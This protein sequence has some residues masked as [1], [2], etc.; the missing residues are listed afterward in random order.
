M[1]FNTSIAIAIKNKYGGYN[2]NELTIFQIKKLNALYEDFEFYVENKRI[3]IKIKCP[4][5]DEFHKFSCNLCDV[6]KKEM[7]IYGCE[8]LG[9]P[10]MFMGEP[11]KVGYRVKKYSEINKKS[12]MMI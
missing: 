6:F 7:F 5:C 9:L 11:D 1:T 3:N 8:T 2:I 12:Y 10:V 4:I